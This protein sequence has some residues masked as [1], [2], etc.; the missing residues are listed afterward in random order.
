M[1]TAYVDLPGL[2]TIWLVANDFVGGV[3]YS[4]YIHDLNSLLAQ[5]RA[6]T[7]AQLANI[8]W[9]AILSSR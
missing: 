4:A 1:R 2:V 3:S 8:F 6:N 5:L 9:Q 7:H